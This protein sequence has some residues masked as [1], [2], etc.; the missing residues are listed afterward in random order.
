MTLRIRAR[1]SRP[2]AVETGPSKL[3]NPMNY[4]FAVFIWH[5]F[6]INE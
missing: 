6:T 2:S 4:V 3:E 5:D 1:P